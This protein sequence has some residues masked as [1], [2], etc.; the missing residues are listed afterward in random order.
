VIGLPDENVFQNDIRVKV[1]DGGEQGNKRVI[2]DKT[3][4]GKMWE[5]H[6]LAVSPVPAK[7]PAMEAE[8]APADDADR[9]KN[10]DPAATGSTLAGPPVFTTPGCQSP[11]AEAQTSTG[12]KQSSAADYR[13]PE[14]LLLAR[15]SGH[16][17]YFGAVDGGG[18]EFSNLTEGAAAFEMDELSRCSDL[19]SSTMRQ[20]FLRNR[21]GELSKTPAYEAHGIDVSRG[22]EFPGDEVRIVTDLRVVKAACDTLLALGDG[23]NIAPDV[24]GDFST[25]VERR[26]AYG[27]KMLVLLAKFEAALASANGAVSARPDLALCC[28][29]AMKEIDGIRSKLAE[30]MLPTSCC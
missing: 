22:K 24:G 18:G 27:A 8:T 2:L 10:G 16:G 21:I 28:S 20:N 6:A 23:G 12:G 7:A 3:L 1:V 4:I 9:R 25:Y 26:R 11:A 13:S 5:C 30:C 29:M 14:E 15:I 19:L 17:G